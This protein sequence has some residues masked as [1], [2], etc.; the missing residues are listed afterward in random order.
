MFPNFLFFNNSMQFPDRLP[1]DASC[2]KCKN[3][4][5]SR[6]NKKLQ[7]STTE[8]WNHQGS[9][10][11]IARNQNHLLMVLAWKWLRCLLSPIGNVHALWRRQVSKDSQE[12]KDSSSPASR[13]RLY[14]PSEPH[15]AFVR[16]WF[17]R[18]ISW[19]AAIHGFGE[20][21]KR[22]VCKRKPTPGPPPTPEPYTSQHQKAAP[23]HQE[24]KTCT[25]ALHQ[26]TAIHCETA[27]V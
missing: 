26:R 18:W 13:R 5:Q 8:I 2:L 12:L 22:V 25:R 17:A 15:S 4:T 1:P 7:S 9:E 24:P 3:K 6:R 27:S 16:G 14:N 20:S 11:S 23:E 19:M 21:V 10:A